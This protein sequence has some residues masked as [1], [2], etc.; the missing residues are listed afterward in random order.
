MKNQK[1]PAAI[2]L[3]EKFDNQLKDI[4]AEELR[5]LRL[6]KNTLINKLSPD[7]VVNSVSLV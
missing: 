6:A 2:K 3:I 4:L 5:M 1:R 7:T